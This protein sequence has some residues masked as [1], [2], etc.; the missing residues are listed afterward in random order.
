MARQIRPPPGLPFS[1]I[2]MAEK[3]QLEQVMADFQGAKVVRA[4]TTPIPQTVRL[5]PSQPKTRIR[6]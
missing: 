5:K 3:E 4:T 6:R 2:W 1:A